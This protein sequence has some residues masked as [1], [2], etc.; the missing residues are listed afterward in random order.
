M[1]SFSDL[2]EYQ[3]KAVDWILEN[4]TCALWMMPGLGKTVSTLTALDI[5]IQEWAIHMTIVI[6]PLRVSQMVWPQEPYLWKHLKHLK[7]IS[8]YWPGAPENKICNKIIR[9]EVSKPSDD[10]TAKDIKQREKTID[11]IT[12]HH[13]IKWL[14]PLLRQQAHFYVINQEQ[15]ALLARVLSNHWCF[16]N[17]IIDEA[18]GFGDWSSNRTKALRKVI[19]QTERIVELTGTPAANHIEKLYPQIF[20]LD[21]GERLGETVTSFRKKY[22]YVGFDGFSRIPNGWMKN[23]KTRLL[24]RVVDNDNDDAKIQIYRKVEDKCMSMME[25]DYLDVPP[26]LPIHVDIQLPPKARSQYDELKKDF[27]VCFDGD[28]VI[29]PKTAAALSNKMLQFCNGAVY[30]D[31]MMQ[32]VGFK[33]EF[34][35]RDNGAAGKQWKE[36]HNA[37]LDALGDIIAEAQ[38]EPV[39]VAFNY[40]HD[41]IRLKKRFKQLRTLDSIEVERQWNRKEIEVMAVHPASAGHG[42]NLQ[43]GSRTLVWFGLTW[44]YEW[45]DQLNRRLK[46]QGQ[47]N[48][49]LAHHLIVQDSIEDLMVMPSLK[50]KGMSMT[51]LLIFMKKEL[52]K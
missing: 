1:K 5:L 20:L 2:H 25:G 7:Y 17:I 18:S 14:K 30:L 22:F 19:Y 11:E 12:Y 39:L 31:G 15:V 41:L 40:K 51:D 26:M 4:K 28:Q 46:R 9:E 27:L 35:L 48:T 36:V 33:D 6:A 34:F 29:H 13:Y 37:K 23:K 16:D 21:R 45:Y 50:N 49:V 3:R 43:Y 10:D 32:N 24:E 44:N 52:T 42:L 38:G 8:L 47:E